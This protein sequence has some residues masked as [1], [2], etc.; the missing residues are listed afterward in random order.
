MPELKRHKLGV[1]DNLNWFDFE[2]T[3]I[4]Y[5]DDKQLDLPVLLC[6][7][8]VG[9]GSNDFSEFID[10][11]KEYFRIIAIDWPGQGLSEP[12]QD[13]HQRH[14]IQTYSRLAIRLIEKLD[15]Q[16]LAVIGNSIGGGVALNIAYLLKDQRHRIKAIVVC[17]PAGVDKGGLLAKLFIGHMVKKFKA[18][19]DKKKTFMDW[20][21]S[22]YRDVLPNAN[23][24]HERNLIA[25]A[26]Y[27]TAPVLEQAWL[28]FKDPMNDIRPFLTQIDQPVLIAWAS[29]DKYVKWN[30]CK[31]GLEKIRNSKLIFFELSGHTPFLEQPQE[32]SH[33]FKQFL[34]NIQQA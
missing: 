5:R 8:A 26:G 6:L 22:Y 17:N 9:H 12:F 34:T 1:R 4:A 23:A 21:R 24:E 13:P 32:F 27:E 18:G 11:F 14:S 31:D 33:E 10:E 28:S 16:N 29:K 20:F 2:G 19:V 3:R 30:R 15:L 25:N 7:H